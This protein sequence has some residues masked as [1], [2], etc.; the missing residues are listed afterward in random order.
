MAGFVGVD[1]AEPLLQEPP[2]DD[3]AE[4]RQ[5]VSHVDDLVKPRPEEALLSALASN[6]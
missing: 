1:R 4:L 5:R 6:F 2:L 3:L